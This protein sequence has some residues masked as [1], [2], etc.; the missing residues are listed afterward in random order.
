[1][2][3]RGLVAGAALWAGAALPAV[4]AEFKKIEDCVVGAAVA[5]RNGRTGRIVEVSSGMCAVK[6][7]GSGEKRSY[8]FWMLRAAGAGQETDDAL[9]AGRYACHA[10]IGA[11]MT[12]AHIDVIIEGPD[13]YRDKQGARGRYRL[14]PDKRIVFET[15]SLSKVDGKLL[16]GPKIGL[17]PEGGRYYSTVCD[18][19]R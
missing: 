10:D 18:L 11:G 15:G 2:F 1:M 12:Y 14:E 4:A 6:I 13:R 19:K 3:W 9:V 17:K 16:A 8:L 7:D 5:D